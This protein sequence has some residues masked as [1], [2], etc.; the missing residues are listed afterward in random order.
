MKKIRSF[1]DVTYII[2]NKCDVKDA[3]GHTIPFVRFLGISL[4]E[5]VNLINDGTW[6]YSI[7][8]Q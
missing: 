7:M 1:S 8:D 5:I 6:E 4:L 3:M 2:N